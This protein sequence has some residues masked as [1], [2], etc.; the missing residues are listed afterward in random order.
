M[1]AYFSSLL[2]ERVSVYLRSRRSVPIRT[3]SEAD[4]TFSAR[5]L[6]VNQSFDTLRR[7]KLSECYMRD[8]IYM[9]HIWVVLHTC[10][11]AERVL[12][13]TVALTVKTT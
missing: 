1:E 9:L 5:G 11:I 2:R 8:T 12:R 4:N 3:S 10:R 13:F 7:Q 6:T